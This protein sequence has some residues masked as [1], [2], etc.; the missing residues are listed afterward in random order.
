MRS[1]FLPFSPPLLGDEEITE[2]LDT[3]R[4]SWLTTGPKTKRFEK[5]FAS[6]V[7]SPDALAVSSCTDALQVA[8]AA[9]GIGEGDAVFTTTMTFCSTVHVIEHVGA[10]PVLVDVEPATMNIDPAALSAA[11]EQVVAEGRLRPRAIIPVHF[12]GH[13]CDMEAI[14]AVAAAHDLALVEDAAHALPAAYR[15]RTIG[16]PHAPSSI[17]RATAFSFYAT[18]NIT[19]GE[20]GM[21]TGPD[22]F[23]EEARLWSL[24]GM[25][26]DAWKRYG[27]GGSWFYE[28]I[29]PGFKCNMTDIQ[30]AIGLRQLERLDGFQARRREVVQQY[31]DLLGDCDALDL[32]VERDDVVSAWHLFPIRLRLDALDIDRAAF[33]EEL[34]NRNIGASVHFIP[35]HVHPYYRDRYRYA[36]EDFPVAWREYQRLIS[37]PLHPGLT[38]ADVRDVGAA[39][40]DVVSAHHR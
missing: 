2:V 38:D 25:S 12:G 32:P 19:T 39:V 16:D 10:R 7:H 11:V 33:I 29:R 17:V 31:E 27:K 28:V 9:L 30:A 24:H 22:D 18:K 5:E 20:G 36:P 23:L 21:L 1:T 35:I 40:L 14:E 34:T 3:L 15:G 6:L 4:G 26:R 13:P 8:L 37:L